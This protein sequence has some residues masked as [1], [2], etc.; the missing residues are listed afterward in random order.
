V[1]GA[2]KI[3]GAVH[4]RRH[5]AGAQK[6]QTLRPGQDVLEATPGLGVEIWRNERPQV[7]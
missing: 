6:A 7:L 5:W 3:Q 2:R 4:V 1:G